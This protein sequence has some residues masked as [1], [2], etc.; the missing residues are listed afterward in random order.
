MTGFGDA[1][2]QV[3]TTH[4]AV[5]VRSVNNRYFKVVIRLPEELAGTEA[6][7]EAQLRKRLIR[8]SVTLT[9]KRRD[10]GVNPGQEINEQALASYL[11]QVEQLHQTVLANDRTITLDLTSLL[12]LPGVLGTPDRQDQILE[13]ARPVITRLTDRACDRLLAMRMVEGQAIA[14]DLNKQAAVVHDRLDQI[15]E[16]APLVSEEYHKRLRSRIDDLISRADIKA[17]QK[18]LIHEVAI[19]AERADISEEITR[20]CGHLDQ[21][22]QF[23]ATAD[24][25]P[26]G[27]TLDFIAQEL[28]RE[29][30]TI[31]SKS[32]DAQISRAIVEVKG[33]I[34]R[35]KE[36]V[37][38]VE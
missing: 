20:M 29:A 12:T 1:S 37:Q 32:N 18:D 35:I 4:Y 19:F 31:A 13:L 9:V 11:K 36:Q 5:E 23:L 30:N 2:E 17:E 24:G 22:D 28:L 27:R 38:N 25:E 3:E 26:S 10:P 34:D 6:E 15:K 16:R 7:L 21:F 14:D 33:A 8:G